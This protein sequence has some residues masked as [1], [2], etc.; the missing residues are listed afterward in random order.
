MKKKTAFVLTHESDPAR[1]S[2]SMSFIALAITRSLGRKGVPVVRVHPNRLDRSLFSKYCKKVEVSPDFYSS[3]ASLLGFLLSM[4]ND[5]E[6]TRL[7]IPASD[8]CAYF[9]A[10]YHDVLSEVFEVVA[11]KREVMETILDKKCQYERAQSLGIPIPE[12][13]FPSGV[14]E[15]KRLAAELTNYPYVIKPLVAHTWRHASMKSVSEG[16]KGFAVQ[17]PLELIG[18]YEAIAQRDKNVMIQEVIGGTDQLLFTFLS[19]FNAESQP[20]GYCIRKKLRQL[21]LDFGYCTMTV[22]C[23][24]EVVQD[25]S[26]R[27]LRGLG[28]Q[29]ISGVEWKL[30]PRTGKYKLIEVNP[31][32]VNT[33]GIATACGVDLPYIAFKDKVSGG[34]THVTEW[35]DGIKWMDFEQDIWAARELH[36]RGELSLHEW[37]NSLAGTKVDATY[38]S[39]DLRPFAAYFLGFMKARMSQLWRRYFVHSMAG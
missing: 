20:V 2:K 8:D 7:L 6:G 4:K 21:P 11:P 39:D 16:K 27:L 30:D 14:D 5:Y 35:L 38:A 1:T 12:T 32:A 29:G 23:H 13:Y 17:N 28:Y 18:R 37:W 25:Q 26:I 36:Q 24:D 34:E 15:V 33:I 31:R 19:Y 10:K 22:S 9:V 3:E